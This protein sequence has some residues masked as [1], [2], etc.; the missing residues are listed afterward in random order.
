MSLFNTRKTESRK[1]RSEKFLLSQRVRINP[2][3]P[4]IA[5]EA[6]AEFK[7]PEDAV[8]RAV[9]A[10]LAAQIAI[11]ICN[12]ETGTESAEFFTNIIGE[13]GLDNELTADGKKNFAAANL[14]R[15]FLPRTQISFNGELRCVCR[16]SGRAVFSEMTTCRSRPISPTHPIL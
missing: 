9:T 3:L 11:D 15:A 14:R 2:N 10:F 12:G 6:D 5:N 8:K 16:Y 1:E 7:S 13:L 4:E